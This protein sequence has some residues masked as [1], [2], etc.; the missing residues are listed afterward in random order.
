MS[1]APFTV[2]CVQVSAGD[3]MA[4]GLAA[5]ARLGHQAAAAGAALIAF[6][7]CVAMIEPDQARL[8]AKAVA[9]DGHPGLAC[10]VELA[11]ETG[12]WVLVGSLAIARSDGR[13]ANRSF[14]IGPAG[15]VVARYDKIHMF[16][17]DLPG[18]ERYRESSLYAAGDAACLAATPW[19]LLGMTIC[20]DLRF[21]GLYRALAGAG[22]G[23]LAVPSAFTRATGAAHW[24]VLLRARAIETGCFVIAPAQCGR[25]AGGRETFGHSLIVD[26][27]GRVLAD[28][29]E[30][31]GVVCAEIDPGRVAEAR[32]AIPSLDHAPRWDRPVAPGSPLRT[33]VGE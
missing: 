4:L 1:A 27:W 23:M 16:D 8:R 24:H 32:R 25:H 31:P 13:L 5:A 15:A 7:E 12:C 3:E 29:G 18:G 33:T 6:P 28:G 11:K 2:A 22:A 26:P 21:P 20:Y 30:T 19:G 14:L 17:V 10:F 9:E